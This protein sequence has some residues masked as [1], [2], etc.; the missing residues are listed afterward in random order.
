M[1]PTNDIEHILHKAAVRTRPEMDQM[2]MEKVLAA[3]Q[4]AGQNDAALKR[5]GLRSMIM[6][7]PTM[8]LAIAALIVLTVITGVYHF[9]TSAP[10]FAEVIKPL[11]TAR[12]TVYE[13]TVQVKGKPSETARWMC[14][15]ESGTREERPGGTVRIMRED[16]VIMLWPAGK[17][18]VIL[19]EINMPEDEQTQGEQPTWFHEIRS[20]IQQ[21]QEAEEESIEFLGKQ[22][23]DGLKA[24]VYSLRGDSQTTNMTVWADS[25]TLMPIRIEHPM[26]RA[27]SVMN[28]EGAISYSDIVFDVELDESLFAVP[29]GYEV[30]TIEIDRSEPSEN[31]L[32]RALRVWSE[33]TDGNF[34]SELNMKTAGQ[35]FHVT[36]EKMGLNGLKPEEDEPPEFAQPDFP[37]FFAIRGTIIRGL[38]FI[39]KLGPARD[40][41]YTNE[42]TKLGDAETTVF[43]YRPEGSETY[44][45]IYGDL[46]VEDARLENLPK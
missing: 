39:S 8:K 14:K 36:R 12:N 11:L 31:D 6:K 23:I 7:S 42:S 18:A 1:K 28:I 43:W 30:D 17:K 37:E 34:P 10:A 33:N 27:N 38:G 19:K 26:G 25:E 21:A 44:R 29:A 40:W 24:L 13:L 22:E 16:Q 3:Q 15:R 32:I 46:R 41:H 45:V 20:R 9:G 2:V 5:A 4:S 35:L